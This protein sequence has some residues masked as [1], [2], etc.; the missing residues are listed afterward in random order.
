MFVDTD[1]GGDIDANELK[2]AAR[3]LGF[4]PNPRELKAM[5]ARTGSVRVV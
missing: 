4:E 5:L 2:F 1:S 3:A